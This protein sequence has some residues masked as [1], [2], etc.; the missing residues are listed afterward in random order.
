MPKF[1]YT[2]IFKDGKR[3]TARLEAESEDAALSSL[4]EQGATVVSIALAQ[5]EKTEA[6]Q[7]GEAQ[8]RFIA[9]KP[10]RM[11]YRVK[12]VDL[13]ILAKQLS[14]MLAAGVN[15]LRSLKIISVQIQSRKLL[16]AV[17]AIK[18]DVEAGS[19]FSAALS[20]HPSVFPKLW[21][22][23]SEAGEASGN[24]PFVLERLANFLEARADFRSKLVSAMLYPLVLFAVA[25]IAI[26]VFTMVIIPKFTSIFA[27]FQIE[28]PLITKAFISLSNILQHGIIFIIVGIAISVLLLKTFLKTK[29]GK[30]LFDSLKLQLPIFGEFIQS[31]QV[32]NFSS[33]ISMLLESGV[34]ILYSLEIVEHSMDNSLMQEA[35]REIKE[36]VRQGQTINSPME[37]SGLFPAMVIQMI[38]IGEE[39]GELPK[40]CK[41]IAIYYEKLVETF[42]MRL[43]SMLEPVMIVFMGLII[44][45]MI[46][47]MYLPIFQ[48]AS[49]G[50]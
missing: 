38:S 29:S 42:V 6:N 9:A 31:V 17:E 45:T 32:E 24:L 2:V 28:L 44:G 27:T 22:N 35:V 10:R 41:E 33:Q 8:L 11:H 18:K 30:R 26:L 43:T 12:L 48:I 19:N 14:T 20:E 39:I 21:I 1:I 23:L 37:K 13:V 40:M 16:K 5:E 47:A 7:S 46:I 15:L 34:P 36:S 4:Q 3:Q 25:I 50:F 49:G